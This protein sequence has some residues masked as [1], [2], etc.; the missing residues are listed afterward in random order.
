VD[1]VAWGQISVK[2][3]VFLHIAIL[4]LLDVCIFHPG[5]IFQ[6]WQGCMLIGAGLNRQATKRGSTAQ[7]QPGHF[8]YVL[9][10]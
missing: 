3:T 5:S 2:A 6:W 4:S 10:V 1:K 9:K 8:L 7:A